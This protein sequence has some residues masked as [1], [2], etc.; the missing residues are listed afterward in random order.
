MYYSILCYP[1][2]NIIIAMKDYSTTRLGM[3][4]YQ[5]AVESTIKSTSCKL[6]WDR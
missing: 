3:H 4:G 2:Y 6:S 5:Y 1:Y